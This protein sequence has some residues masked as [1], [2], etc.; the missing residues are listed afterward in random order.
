MSIKCPD[1]GI[2]V[3]PVLPKGTI[4]WRGLAKSDANFI[5][6][7]A[8]TFGARPTFCQKELNLPIVY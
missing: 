4:Y 3:G 1:S 6:A 5:R 8:I 7:V 2:K